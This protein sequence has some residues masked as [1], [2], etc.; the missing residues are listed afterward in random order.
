MRVNIREIFP[1]QCKF[2]LLIL[3]INV[4]C[5]LPLSVVALTSPMVEGE[6]A[7]ESGLNSVHSSGSGTFLKVPVLTGHRT[8]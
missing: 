7:S 8:S 4:V 1:G 6:S 2:V 3:D 5:E